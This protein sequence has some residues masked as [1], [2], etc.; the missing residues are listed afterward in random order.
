MKNTHGTR[1]TYTAGCRCDKCRTANST[2]MNRY[3]QRQLDKTTRHSWRNKN[4]WEAWEDE[5]TL[6]YSKT[7]WQIADMLERTPAAVANRRRT[8]LARK[9]NQ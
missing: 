7:A 4:R 1:T 6:D 2:Y 5:L 9:N 8:L 3:R